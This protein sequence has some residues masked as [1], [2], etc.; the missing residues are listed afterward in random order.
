MSMGA[1]VALAAFLWASATPAV[2]RPPAAAKSAD[3]RIA[4]QAKNTGKIGG[5]ARRSSGGRIGGR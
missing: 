1:G 5:A 4:G 2:A 3:G